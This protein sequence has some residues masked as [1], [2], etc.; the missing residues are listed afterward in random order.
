MDKAS[1]LINLGWVLTLA[2]TFCVLQLLSGLA[3]THYPGQWFLC[4]VITEA[5]GH[6]THIFFALSAEAVMAL[7]AGDLELVAVVDEAVGAL[8]RRH[9]ETHVFFA[10]GKRKHQWEKYSTI[11]NQNSCSCK[12][13]SYWLH[14]CPCCCLVKL[15]LL[16]VCIE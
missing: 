15:L 4:L 16:L 5:E 3:G 7:E 11:K 2:M 14:F 8:R 1:V 13:F 12:M 9:G 6:M 10:A